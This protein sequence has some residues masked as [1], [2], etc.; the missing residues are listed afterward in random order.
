MATYPILR[1]AVDDKASGRDGSPVVDWSQLAVDTASLPDTLSSMI[2]RLLLQGELPAGARLPTE[3]QLAAQL[4]VSRASVREAIHELRLKG[5]VER[6]PGRGTVVLNADGASRG[7]L[8]LGMMAPDSRDLRSILDFREAIEPPITSR[9]AL[10]ATPSDLGSLRAVVADMERASP[11]AYGG[12]DRHFHLLV[13]RTT[14]NPLLERLADVTAEWM[15]S[16]RRDSLQSPQRRTAS[17]SGHRAILDAIVR[18]DA[19]AAAAA[20]LAHVRSVG[21]ILTDSAPATSIPDRVDDPRAG[22]SPPD[23]PPPRLDRG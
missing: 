16:I 20:T 8:L 9:A 12:L 2:E 18:H 14:H 10:R 23:V 17:M 7:D 3:R 13:A 22:A 21:S 15:A 4:G 19:E 6:R 11:A 1:V 5:L